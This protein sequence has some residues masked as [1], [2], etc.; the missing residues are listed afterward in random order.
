MWGLTGDPHKEALV[1]ILSVFLLRFLRSPERE[2]QRR[3]KAESFER[4]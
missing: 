3:G 4:P 1:D 2:S